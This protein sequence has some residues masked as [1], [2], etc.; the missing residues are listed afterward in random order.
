MPEGM[1]LENLA[2]LKE[3]A[4][5]LN[6]SDQSGSSIAAVFASEVDSSLTWKFM[7]WIRTVTKLPVFA[8]VSLTTSRY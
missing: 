5:K 3:K 4:D 1:A 7:D 8:K 6:K 2:Q